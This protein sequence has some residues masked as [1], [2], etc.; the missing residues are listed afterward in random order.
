[1]KFRRNIEV[2]GMI[3]KYEFFKSRDILLV[4]CCYVPRQEK[5]YDFNYIAKK[6]GSFI[7]IFILK[8][9]DEEDDDDD[10]DDDADDGELFLRN[11]WPTKGFKVYWLTN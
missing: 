7:E 2:I 1:M 4:H 11:G 10:D 8:I 3:E 9:F 5:E 6:A